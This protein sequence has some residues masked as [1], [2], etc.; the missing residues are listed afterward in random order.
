MKELSHEREPLQRRAGETFSIRKKGGR[1]GKG[2]RN[3]WRPLFPNTFDA[4][5][6]GHLSW[7]EQILS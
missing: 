1:T 2:T 6:K 7:L 3:N 4:L 5:A